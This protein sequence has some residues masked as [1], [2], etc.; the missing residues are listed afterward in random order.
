[1]NVCMKRTNNDEIIEGVLYVTPVELLIILSALHDLA[2]CEERNIQDR[3]K[4]D[5]IR[6]EIIE[7][8]GGEK[9]DE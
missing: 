3:A 8:L 9:N 7:V 4:A 5:L 2:E 1:M 6:S